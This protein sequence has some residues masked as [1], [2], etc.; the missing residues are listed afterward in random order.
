MEKKSFVII[1]KT[2]IHARPATEIVQLANKFESNSF[3]EYNGR[4]V[5]MKSIMGLMS[6]GVPYEAEIT[7]TF[8]GKDEV[9]AMSTFES[10]IKAAG[11]VAYL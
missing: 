7:I 6:L 5:N 10:S 9:D 8:E 11:L 4:A 1:D 2:G 3:M